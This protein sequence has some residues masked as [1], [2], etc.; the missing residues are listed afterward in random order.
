[1]ASKMISFAI[2][3]ERERGRFS[4]ETVT[5]TILSSI[6]LLFDIFTFSQRK[7]QKGVQFELHYFPFT[8]HFLHMAVEMAYFISP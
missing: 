7:W 2:R 8:N 5:E 3:I 4:L 1:M 6:L